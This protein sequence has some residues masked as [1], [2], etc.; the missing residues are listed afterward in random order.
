MDKTQ[1]EKLSEVDGLLIELME[2][3]N[4]EDRPVI[5]KARGLIHTIYDTTDGLVKFYTDMLDHM[6]SHKGVYVNWQNQSIVE[7]W[8]ATN[9]DRLSKILTGLEG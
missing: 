5:G 7:T 8:N 4:E 9:K 2:H 3:A 6:D 1:K